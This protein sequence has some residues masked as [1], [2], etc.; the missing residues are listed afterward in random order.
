M[1]KAELVS[2]LREL[3]TGEEAEDLTDKLIEGLLELLSLPFWLRPL[4]GFLRR[5]LDAF[6]PE[7]LFNLLERVLQRKE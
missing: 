2:G 7:G 4:K 1:D 6:L 3:F 5:R